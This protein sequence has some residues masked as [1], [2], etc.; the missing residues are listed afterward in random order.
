MWNSPLDWIIDIAPQ[1][2]AKKRPV[3]IAAA[4]C[5]QNDMYCLMDIVQPADI[6][7]RTLQGRL[8]VQS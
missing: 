7:F 2:A 6:F 8:P 5:A 1:I 4:W 3:G